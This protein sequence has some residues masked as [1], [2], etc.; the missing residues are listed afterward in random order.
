MWYTF[1]SRKFFEAWC[2]YIL[3][4]NSS[5]AQID[6]L[7]P[8]VSDVYEYYR[9]PF[10]WESSDWLVLGAV[11]SAVVVTNQY[12]EELKAYTLQ[13]R[14]TARKRVTDFG[15]LWTEFDVSR[16]LMIGLWLG[17]R[18]LDKNSWEQTAYDMVE[19][20][21]LAVSASEAI[22]ALTQ[23]CRPNN[24]ESNHRWN[25]KNCGKAF[26]S[27]HTTVGFAMSAALVQNFSQAGA[28]LS[29]PAYTFAMA[30]AFGRIYDNKHWLSDV[31][32]GAALGHFSAQFIINRRRTQRNKVLHPSLWLDANQIGVRYIW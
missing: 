1:I 15:Y 8:F 29:I 11:A 31:I 17:G 19:T 23:R 27:G 22:K 4:M 18:I 25:E 5:V 2:L 9:Q 16:P 21:F 20:G 28:W 32:A 26:P 12:D 10:S 14:S 3:A 30:G 7:S 6:R 13:H 24:A